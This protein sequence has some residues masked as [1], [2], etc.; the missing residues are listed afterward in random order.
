M[1]VTPME[2][3]ASLI[4]LWSLRVAAE[5]DDSYR[6]VAKARDSLAWHSLENEDE[7]FLILKGHLRVELEHGAVDFDEGDVFEV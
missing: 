5:V 6:K 7:L 2:V 3:A 1:N 4:E